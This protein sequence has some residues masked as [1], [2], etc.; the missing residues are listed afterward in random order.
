M[1]NKNWHSESYADLINKSIQDNDRKSLSS[2]FNLWFHLHRYN[3]QKWNEDFKNTLIEKGYNRQDVF[4]IFSFSI[5]IDKTLHSDIQIVLSTSSCL[6]ILKPVSEGSS[7]SY[8]KSLKKYIMRK[9]LNSLV[10][11]FFRITKLNVS[12]TKEAIDLI[13]KNSL[14][15]KIFSQNDNDIVFTIP[16]NRAATFIF[17][18]KDDVFSF[19]VSISHEIDSIIT[20]PHFVI[21]KKSYSK[22]DYNIFKTEIKNNT[23][24]SYQELL[25]DYNVRNKDHIQNIKDIMNNNSTYFLCRHFDL[26]NFN[27]SQSEQRVV[28]F[29]QI[30]K[31]F[32]HESILPP[33]MYE[34]I[35]EEYFINNVNVSSDARSILRNQIISRAIQSLNDSLSKED[36]SILNIKLENI[37]TYM[38]YDNSFSKKSFYIQSKSS[39][40]LKD[41]DIEILYNNLITRHLYNDKFKNDKSSVRTYL[42]KEVLNNLISEISSKPKKDLNKA[43]IYQELSQ[44]IEIELKDVKALIKKID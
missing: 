35:F 42:L 1:E 14:S 2:L 43:E 28:D 19:D 7:I 16:K 34:I 8:L 33:K 5:S 3:G 18:N 30:E 20:V 10:F 13:S 4:D 24:L 25:N 27:N 44:Y 31:S 21:T 9:H 11:N 23:L 12:N 32:I 41:S 38:N 39:G 29:L 22:N 37:S 36:Q 15:G 6:P 40:V 26:I 17:K